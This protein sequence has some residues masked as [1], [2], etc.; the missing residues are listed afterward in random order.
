[1][2]TFKWSR[3]P[4]NT[5]RRKKGF[6]IT[7]TIEEGPLY[8]FGTIDIQSNIRAVDPQSLRS[9]LRMKQG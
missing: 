2:P 6:I 4:A 1:M 3:R 7:F 8:H 9:A 5:I